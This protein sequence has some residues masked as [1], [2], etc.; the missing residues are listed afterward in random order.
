[1]AQPNHCESHDWWEDKQGCPSCVLRIVVHN[2]LRMDGSFFS[3]DPAEGDYNSLGTMEVRDAIQAI[4]LVDAW[5]DPMITG[6]CSPR[7]HMTEREEF[8]AALELADQELP[9]SR[10]LDGQMKGYY[11]SPI[12]NERWIGWCLARGI[13]ENLE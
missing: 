6:P 9:I 8:E 4:G 2:L 1:M 5:K 11:T 10:Y 3:L 12:T 13:K 7:Y